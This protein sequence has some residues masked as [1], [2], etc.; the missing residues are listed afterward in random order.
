[1]VL[2]VPTCS[3]IVHWYTSLQMFRW[4]VNFTHTHKYTH[5]LC[6]CRWGLTV[7]EEYMCVWVGGCGGGGQECLLSVEEVGRGTFFETQEKA[8]RQ[9]P[10]KLCWVSFRLDKSVLSFVTKCGIQTHQHAQ[11]TTTH[12]HKHVDTV[13]LQMRLFQR[14]VISE[15]YRHTEREESTNYVMSDLMYGLCGRMCSCMGGGGLSFSCKWSGVLVMG[16]K[17]FI[18]SF[19]CF[20]MDIK[21]KEQLRHYGEDVRVLLAIQRGAWTV[22]KEVRLSS[23]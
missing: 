20:N 2:Q 7:G 4:G 6:C 8:I 14:K 11:Y 9:M 5:L 18:H 21:E 12:G 22:T 16:L 15:F 17:T 13:G 23:E 10:I 19:C 1:M 3:A